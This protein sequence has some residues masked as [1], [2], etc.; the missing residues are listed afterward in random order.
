MSGMF[1]D[2]RHFTAKRPRSCGFTL[3]ELLVTLTVLGLFFV[4]LT[5]ALRLGSRTW[6]VEQAR[7]AALGEMEAVHS[8][9]RRILTQAQPAVIP[10]PPEA[11]PAPALIGAADGVGFIA[12]MP[13]YLSAVDVAAISLQIDRSNQ[14]SR[15]IVT[16]TP[17]ISHA[18]APDTTQSR[19]TVLV[20]NVRKVEFS[21]FG[22]VE[23]VGDM[24]RWNDEWR[25]TLSMPWLVRMRL[26][27]NDAAAWPDLIVALRHADVPW[28]IGDRADSIGDTVR[29]K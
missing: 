9:I 7:S 15:L 10:R 13:P 4:M 26:V 29:V 8:F 6:E 11:S 19:A 23:E 12:P 3:V 24:P 17:W 27:T 20:D 2:A 5:G 28:R 16:W 22:P 21:Y 18:L 25:S 14:L 1:V